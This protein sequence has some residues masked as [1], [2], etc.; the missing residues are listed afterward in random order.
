MFQPEMIWRFFERRTSRENVITFSYT[1]ISRQCPFKIKKALE[2]YK[3]G[4]GREMKDGE[5]SFVLKCM[6]FH[7]SDSL[8][9]QLVQM[10]F[11]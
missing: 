2:G 4:G 6:T 7:Q 1:C 11:S 10:S 5:E 8:W 3:G 9:E